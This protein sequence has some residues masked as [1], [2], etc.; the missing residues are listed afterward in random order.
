[1][2]DSEIAGWDPGLTKRAMRVA[3][4]IVKRYYRSEVHGLELLPPGGVLVAS[5]HS[6]GFLPMDEVV[7]AVDYY[8]EFGYTRPIYTLTH[9]IM[10]VGPTADS[11]RR[12]GYVRATRANAAEAL[13]AGAVVIDFPGGDYDAYRPTWS[14]NTIDSVAASAT[15]ARPSTPRFPSFRW[16]PLARKRTSCFC[17]AAPG[18]RAPFG[19]TSCR[20]PR[21]CPSRSASRSG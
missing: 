14:R 12:L 21:S 3:R 10:L 17:R 9:D 18:W 4:P 11:L 20:I 5:N 1:M 2:N 13:R 15:P 6:G 8:G 16:F 19:W 7:F